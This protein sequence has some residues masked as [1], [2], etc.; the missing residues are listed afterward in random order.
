MEE[1]V[2]IP[3]AAYIFSLSKFSKQTV[4]P[5]GGRPHFQCVKRK[6]GAGRTGDLPDCRLGSGKDERRKIH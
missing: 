5:P 4:H 2:W 3:G 6:Y 1:R